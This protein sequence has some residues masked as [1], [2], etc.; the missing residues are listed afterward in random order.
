MASQIRMDAT[1]ET[2]NNYLQELIGGRDVHMGSQVWYYEADKLDDVVQ[3]MLEWSLEGP[4]FIRVDRD[5]TC[6]YREEGKIRIR[7][8]DSLNRVS[9]RTF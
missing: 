1:T 7:C 5:M 2:L 8:Q 6:I 4:L 9:E 3:A